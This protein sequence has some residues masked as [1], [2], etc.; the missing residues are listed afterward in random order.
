MY[1]CSYNLK[2]SMLTSV[3]Q[4]G[5]IEQLYARRHSLLLQSKL[6]NVYIPLLKGSLDDIAEPSQGIEEEDAMDVEDSQVM[7]LRY[8]EEDKL[9]VDFSSIP[10]SLR[11]RHW[12]CVLRVSAYTRGDRTCQKH[13]RRLSTV[14]SWRS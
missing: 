5:Q 6:D 10:R 13:K 4:A 3:L 8:G 9:E 7:Q 11:V 1:G 14:R 12:R 2:L